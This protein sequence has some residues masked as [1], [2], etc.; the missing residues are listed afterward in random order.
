[1]ERITSVSNN[2]IKDANNLKL[3]KFR[4]EKELFFVEGLRTVEEAVN[5]GLVRKV[6]YTVTSDVR[7]I[8]VIDKAAANGADLYEVDT[9]VMEKLSDTKEPQGIIAI[10]DI[11]KVTMNNFGKVLAKVVSS[12][13]K[14]FAN[15]S[16]VVV[17]RIQDPGNLGSIIRAADAAGAL[18]IVLL[19]GTVDAFAPKVVRASMG[20]L[21]H[22]PIVSDVNEVDCL[23]WCKSEGYKTLVTCLD[24]ASD[25]YKTNLDEK[26]AIVM[27]NDANGISETLLEKADLKAFIPMLG[28]AESLNV[29]VAIVVILYERFSQR[30]YKK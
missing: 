1:M 8:S 28:S 24:G 17:D 4:K 22:L 7:T 30:Q 21:F 15:A 11:P 13:G 9:K 18:G 6:F 26:L 10:A 16:V 25:L 5:Y 29:G 12:K 27:G 14:D 20:S 2:Q 23:A 3:K 19:N